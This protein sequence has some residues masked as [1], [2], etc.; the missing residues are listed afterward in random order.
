MVG[1]DNSNDGEVLIFAP[2]G[3]DAVVIAATLH[4]AGM[5]PRVVALL[6]DLTPALTEAATAILVEEALLDA[7]RSAIAQWV[8]GQPPWS[9]FPFLLLTLRGDPGSTRT[10]HLVELLGNVTILERPLRPV[11]LISAAR[12]AIRARQRQRQS[13]AYLRERERAEIALRNLAA[14]LEERVQERTRQLSEANDRLT[15]EIVERERTEAALGQAQ[16]MEAIG[17]LTGGVAHDFN[18]LLTAVLGNLE[19]LTQRVQDPRHARLIRNAAHAA[20]RGAKLTEQLLAFSRRQ[21]LTPRPIDVNELIRGMQ[22][23]LS[24]TIG[25][26]IR[27]ETD[28]ERGLGSALVDTTQLELV[29]LNLAI[30][31]RDA[32]P[33]GGSLRIQTANLDSV[34]AALAGELVPQ[35]Y[36]VIS[37][38]DSGT[39][40]SPEIAARAFEPFFTTKELGRGT[41]LGLS[42]VYGFAKQSGGTV[43]IESRPGQGTSVRIYLP[44]SNGRVRPVTV[45]DQ[46]RHGVSGRA[47]ILVVDDDHDVRQLV[48]TMLQDLGY[49]VLAA[50]CGRAALEMVNGHVAV[51][52]LL[53]DVAMPGMNGLEL[54]RIMRQRNVAAHV[55]FASGYADIDAFGPALQGEDLIRKP[56]RMAELSSRLRKVLSLDEGG[57]NQARG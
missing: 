44:R 41:G 10:Q 16:K 19:L 22:E 21:R 25:Q 14:T 55:L 15:A 52:L 38:C 29:I 57:L 49:Q 3:R 47:T 24:R 54:V 5:Q 30:N 2:G 12:S 42:Q 32:M 36:V 39:G 31:A 13:R 37:V 34:P 50:D 18:N 1:A 9:D 28:L 7:D 33:N 56:F 40:M 35:K 46:Q 17:Q 6:A 26:T 43:Q 27:I 8:A 20:E 48:V 4:G 23:L 53:V 11:T 51:D 45:E